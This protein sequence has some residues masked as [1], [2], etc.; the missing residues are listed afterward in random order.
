MKQIFLH[1]LIGSLLA[2]PLSASAQD[3]DDLD[4]P[5]I[6]TGERESEARKRIREVTRTIT[7]RPRVD[8]PVARQYGQ[9]CVGVVGLSA[10]YAS[11]LI[12][13]VEANARR[14]GIQVA[15]E[16]CKVNTLIAFVKD[17][18]EQVQALR[19]EM[20]WLFSTLLDYEYDRILRNN[21]GALAWHA[22]QVK[23]VDGK[24]L[25]TI[26]IGNPPRDVQAGDPF[27]ATRMA[28][29][30]RVDMLGSVVVF[31]SDEIVGLTL[32]QLADYA[33]MR[34]F[35][36]VYELSA[37]ESAATPSILSLFKEEDDAA[38]EGLTDFDWA[39]LEAIYKLPRTA[40]GN[41]VHDA[42]WSSYRKKVIRSED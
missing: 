41:A 19:Q 27:N 5:I 31:N 10:D 39:Y 22:T 4:D 34:S 18:R 37:D 25:G 7:Q 32:Q 35:V 42:A 11:T 26:Q 29:Q 16:G 20:P 40:R 33:S 6:V 14:L 21:S 24:E 17:G 30:I 1:I 38:P 3:I 9:I 2:V 12:G 23:E 15:N 8:K 28:Q 36:S 13:Q